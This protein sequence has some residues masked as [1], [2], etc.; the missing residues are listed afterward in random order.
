MTD[1]LIVLEQ[2]PAMN[3]EARQVLDMLAQGKITAEDAAR[4][5]DRLNHPHAD[6]STPP[7]PPP[8]P[9][10]PPAGGRPRFLRV[11]VNSEDGDK[12]NVRVPLSLVS[13]GIK[14]T[15]VMPKDVGEKLKEKG[16]DLSD[17]ASGKG[18][19]VI[20]ALRELQV[21]VVSEDGDQVKIYCE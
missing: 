7:P 21:D 10:T 14:L 16:L 1:D 18:E 12:V 9:P 5:L 6:P 19:A 15:T 17:L 2:E 8:A 4:L 13:A 20:D 11:L 3:S